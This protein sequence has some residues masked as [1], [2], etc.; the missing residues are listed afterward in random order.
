MA[1]EIPGLRAM[2]ELRFPGVAGGSKVDGETI[3]EGP[4]VLEDA[5]IGCSGRPEDE[6][7][8]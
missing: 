3:L 6:T 2:T 7:D 1:D 5:F 4:A 8:G